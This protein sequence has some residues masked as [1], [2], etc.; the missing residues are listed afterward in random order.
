MDCKEA[1]ILFENSTK[2]RVVQIQRCSVGMANYVF[3]VS[4]AR[5]KFIL[6]C[7]KERNAYHDTVFLLNQLSVCDIPI[8][9]VLSEG[10]YEE[11]SY[12]ILSYVDGDDIGK[13]YCEL[14]DSQKKQI[15][16]EVVAIQ[17][18]VSRIEIRAE[19][20]WAWKYHVGG[21]L[22]RAEERI[23]KKRYFD[24]NKITTIRELLPDIQDYLDQIQ[25]VPY[26]DDISTKNL[27][28]CDGKLS[29]IIDIDWIGLGDVLTFAALTR[30]AL[31]NM[32]LDTK[33][34]DY[35]LEELQ[36]NAT[37]YK[38]FV[39]YCLMYCVDFMGE[40][41][42]QFLDKTIPV[43]ESIIRRLNQIFDILMEEWN[44]CCEG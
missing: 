24:I 28:I 2:A 12:L 27:L 34:C 40:R 36:P 42:M 7:S 20:E 44:K 33:Y 38:A 21:M 5:E 6:R 43:D 13:V 16:K 26:L 11:Y 15:A 8:P 22:D 4:T 32:D 14:N 23:R 10:S 9:D 35:L 31:L 3:L 39:F 41:G 25:P 17:R 37:Q 1:A 19:A 18:K 30:V 29:G